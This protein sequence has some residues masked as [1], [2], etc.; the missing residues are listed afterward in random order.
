MCR[1]ETASRIVKSKSMFQ[2]VVAIVLGAWVACTGCQ[3][4]DGMP[5]LPFGDSM[6][7]WQ[8]DQ[9]PPQSEPALDHR[10]SESLS[11]ASPPASD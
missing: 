10:L 7:G 1:P 11:Q 8:L 9:L 4:T 2:P 3:A 5:A 6:L